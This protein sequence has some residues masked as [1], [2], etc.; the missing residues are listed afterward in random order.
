MDQETYE[1]TKLPRDEEWAKYLKE[2]VVCSLLS[3]NGKVSSHH[4]GFWGLL[5]KRSLLRCNWFTA[6]VWIACA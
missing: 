5:T 3:Y 1:E 2:G 4:A 6:L